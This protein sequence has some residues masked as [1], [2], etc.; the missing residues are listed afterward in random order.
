M[1]AEHTINCP[2][3]ASLVASGVDTEDKYFQL[4][5]ER[6]LINKFPRRIRR[7]KRE[8]LKIIDMRMA[9]VIDDIYDLSDGIHDIREGCKI[10]KRCKRCLILLDEKRNA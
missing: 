10:K 6:G 3:I 9:P 2:D 5:Q 7:Q 8:R 1:N 4:L